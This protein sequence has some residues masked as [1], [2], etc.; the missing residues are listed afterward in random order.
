[1]KRASVSDDDWR[2]VP[3]K[4]KNEPLVTKE[5]RRSSASALLKSTYRRKPDIVG[6][7]GKMT[8]R[9]KGNLMG[10]MSHS[11]KKGSVKGSYEILH[12]KQLSLSCDLNVLH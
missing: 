12:F 9:E 5:K 7:E 3:S 11:T 10:N 6:S 1:M 8:S 2:S 4:N